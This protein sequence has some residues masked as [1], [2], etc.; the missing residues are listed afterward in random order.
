MVRHQFTPGESNPAPTKIPSDLASYF[1]GEDCPLTVVISVHPDCPCTSA[2]LE[3]LDRLLTHFPNSSRAIAFFSVEEDAAEDSNYQSNDY[4][5]RID[6]MP[7]AISIMDRGGK[8]A[9]EFGAFVSGSVAGYDQSGTLR[10]Q[11]GITA[12]RGHAG[13]SLGLDA[14]AEIASGKNLSEVKTTATFGCSLMEESD[15]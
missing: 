2:S 7:N 6:K 14:L 1:Q 5:Q 4:W 8:L 15:S 3:Q 12:S 13:P 11:G 9:H 10:F